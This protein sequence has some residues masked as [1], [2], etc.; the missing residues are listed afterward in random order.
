M[1][2]MQHFRIV[3]LLGERWLF[4]SKFYGDYELGHAVFRSK[5]VKKLI[6]D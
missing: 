2:D 5:V 4:E 1:F 6:K 3:Y